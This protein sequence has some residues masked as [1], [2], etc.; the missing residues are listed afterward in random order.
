MQSVSPHGPRCREWVGCQLMHRLLQPTRPAHPFPK[1][2]ICPLPKCCTVFRSSKL[3]LFG[4]NLGVGST[5]SFIKVALCW[6]QDGTAVCLKPKCSALLY[7][8]LRAANSAR[9]LPTSDFSCL[10]LYIQ[11]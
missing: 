9:S 8:S 10:L 2:G 4:W 11:F 5:A 1:F 3:F 6:I 7:G